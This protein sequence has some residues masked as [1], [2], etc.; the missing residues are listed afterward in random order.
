MML[1]FF[2]KFFELFF[3]LFSKIFY[4]TQIFFKLLSKQSLSIFFVFENHGLYMGHLFIYQ[5]L[6][7]VMVKLGNF[8]K[9]LISPLKDGKVGLYL[10][11]R[12]LK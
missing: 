11:A 5:M 7:F 9:G 1:T 12:L 4:L 2:V 3:S 8:F 6:F 10:K